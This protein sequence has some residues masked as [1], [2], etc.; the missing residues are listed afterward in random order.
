MAVI[1]QRLSSYG[2]F[3]AAMKMGHYFSLGLLPKHLEI[4]R[5]IAILEPISVESHIYK[6]TNLRTV[7]VKILKRLSLSLSAY[8]CIHFY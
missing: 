7:F 2:F 3:L 1:A 8:L 4:N 6:V 5:V